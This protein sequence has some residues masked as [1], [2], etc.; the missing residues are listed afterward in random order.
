[1]TDDDL[2]ATCIWTEARGEIYEGKVAVGLIILHRATQHYFST[3]DIESAVLTK[4]Q[5]SA[6]WFD[7]VNGHYTRVCNTLQDA[8]ARAEKLFE[9][10]SASST[11]VDCQRACIDAQSNSAYKGGIQWAKL[12]AEPRALLYANLAISNPAWAKPKDLVAV[13]GHHTFFKA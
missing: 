11:W 3:G 10:A 6:F 2:M 4:D 7:F 5:F 1:M 9:T 13:I 12:A 8:Q